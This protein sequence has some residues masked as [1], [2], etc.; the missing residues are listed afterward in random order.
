MNSADESSEANHGG[1]LQTSSIDLRKR[2][3]K[4]SSYF[5]T[6][7]GVESSAGNSDSSTDFLANQFDSSSESQPST[8]KP[9]I[10]KDDHRT[11]PAAGVITGW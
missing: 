5:F 9:A 1:A 3:S 6:D 10:S 8:G 4:V 2:L 7:V 11:H